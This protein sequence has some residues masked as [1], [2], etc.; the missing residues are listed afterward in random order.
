MKPKCSAVR[1]YDSRLRYLVTSR[2][3]NVDPY[4]V[5][6]DAFDYNG[7][8]QCE[9]FACRLAP[10][11]RAGLT[12]EIAWES[13]LVELPDLG[14][15]ADCLRCYHIQLARLAFAADVL[16]EIKARTNEPK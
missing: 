11:L 16:S 12:A 4:L 9:H 1:R 13:G 6:L 7:E 8:C 14:T 10:L 5:E 3:P 2:R 15:V